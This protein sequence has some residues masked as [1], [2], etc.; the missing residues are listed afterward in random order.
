MPALVKLTETCNYC[1]KH[2]IELMVFSGNVRICSSCWEHHQ[3]TLSML[4]GQGGAINECQ[5]CKVPIFELMDKLHLTAIRMS[6]IVAD[7][8]YQYACKPCAIK[9]NAKRKDLFKG[10]EAENLY[11]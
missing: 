1:S 7:G 2:K 8:I 10:T 4:S 11:V 5:I 3:K 9:H 6:I